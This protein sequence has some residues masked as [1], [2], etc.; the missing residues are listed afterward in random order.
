MVSITERKEKRQEVVCS[1]RGKKGHKREKCYRLVGFPVNFKFTKG[2][3]K[4]FQT[5]AN[6]VSL[7]TEGCNTERPPSDGMFLSQE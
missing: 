3:G 4:Q 2:R 6:Q 5:A 7:Q 1:H